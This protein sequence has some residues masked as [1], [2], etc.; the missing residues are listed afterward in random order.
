MNLF[1]VEPPSA[2]VC[3]SLSSFMPANLFR[4]LWDPVRP[5]RTSRSQ[6]EPQEFVP[7]CRDFIVHVCWYLSVALLTNGHLTVIDFYRF[8]SMFKIVTGEW[9]QRSTSNGSSVFVAM[10]A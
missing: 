2:G 10:E 4:F 7:Y 8:A 3:G 6:N 1:N 9:L 5:H